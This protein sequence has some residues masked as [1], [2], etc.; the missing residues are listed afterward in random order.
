VLECAALR[1]A[2]RAGRALVEP[3]RDRVRHLL[4]RAAHRFGWSPRAVDHWL[5]HGFRKREFIN[6]RRRHRG[7][8][9][10]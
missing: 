2:G 4:Y 1:Q 8:R 3:P 5:T 10:I 9:E 6:T 7:L